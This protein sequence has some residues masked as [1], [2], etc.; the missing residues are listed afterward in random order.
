MLQSLIAWFIALPL[1]WSIVVGTA[2]FAVLCWILSACIIDPREYREGKWLGKTIRGFIFLSLIVGPFYI[3][4][5]LSSDFTI[6]S[7]NI[8]VKSQYIAALS[9]YAFGIV[10]MLV[11]LYRLDSK[12]RK[13]FAENKENYKVQ[14]TKRDPNGPYGNMS[15]VE[16]VSETGVKGKIMPYVNELSRRT[17]FWPFFL[18]ESTVRKALRLLGD[19]YDYSRRFFAWVI[20]SMA[21]TLTN[22]QNALW[23]KHFDE[24]DYEV[25]PPTPPKAKKQYSTETPDIDNIMKTINKQDR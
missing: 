11:H 10:Y 23:K 25:Q 17:I 22:I 9:Y 16:W 5:S 2:S 8:T 13:N 3:I 7:L 21:N 14:Y 24:S 15:F 19:L 12:N 20:R 4:S 1:L 18:F 6:L